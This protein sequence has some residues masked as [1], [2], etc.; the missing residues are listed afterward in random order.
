MINMKSK[1][2]MS[3]TLCSLLGASVFGGI[4][5]EASPHYHHSSPL[6]YKDEDWNP[7]PEPPETKKPAPPIP[8]RDKKPMPSDPNKDDKP[9][10]PPPPEEQ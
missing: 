9:V 3:L 5:A 6:Q 4:V 10:F 2:I 1:K 8:N 7:P